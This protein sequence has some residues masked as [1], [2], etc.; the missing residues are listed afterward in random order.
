MLD[1]QNWVK[2]LNVVMNKFENVNRKIIKI[3]TIIKIVGTSLKSG[4]SLALADVSIRRKSD[5]KL[6]AVGRHSKQI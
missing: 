1:Q 6:V 5:Q 2:Q 4:K 3:K